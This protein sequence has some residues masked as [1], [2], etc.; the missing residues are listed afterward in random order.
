MTFSISAVSTQPVDISAPAPV[1]TRQAPPPQLSS[2]TV[3]LSQSAQVS[4][5]YQLGQSTLQIAENLGIPV[6]TVNSD[7]V[8]IT[9]PATAATAAA[10]LFN[11]S[12][13][14]A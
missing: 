10:A 8:I 9:A 13:P 6:S 7:L 2:D 3:R 1:A 11:K 14:T 5:M 12:A 4:Q